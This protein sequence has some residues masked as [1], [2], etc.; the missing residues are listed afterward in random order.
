MPLTPNEK[1]LAKKIIDE[2]QKNGFPPEEQLRVIRLAR[3]KLLHYYLHTP[4]VMN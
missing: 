1:K 4:Q 2:L 3:R